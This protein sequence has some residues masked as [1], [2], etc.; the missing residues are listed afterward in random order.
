MSF[1][2]KI[3][4]YFRNGAGLIKKAARNGAVE[5][6]I[7][8]LINKAIMFISNIL[9]IRMLDTS[10]YGVFSYIYNIISI[11][12]IF[13]SLG[14]DVTMLQFCCENRPLEE[15]RGIANF[16][17]PVGIAIN[18]TFS[19]ATFFIA[20]FAP[21]KFPEGRMI[22]M[23]FSF[24][25]PF[26]FILNYQKNILRVQK[27]NRIFSLLTN[28]ASISYLI[29]S[30]IFIKFYGMLGATVGRF[31]AYVIPIVFG[32]LFTMHV[33]NDIRKSSFPVKS[34][35]ISIF[36]YGLT[37]ALTNGVSEL[38]YYLDVY[39]IGQVTTDAIAI[40]NYKSATLIPRAMVSLPTIIVTFIYPY[41]A[42]N[43]DKHDWVLR[44][45][46]KLELI[47]FPLC[48][49]AAAVLFIIAPW[50][51][52]F[53]YG[54]EY[55]DSLIPFR[56]LLV[57][58]VF[59]GSFRVLSGNILLMIGKVKANFVV[60]CIECVINVI[61]DY[62]LIK[63]FNTVGAAVATLSVT[64]ISSILT[65]GFLFIYLKKKINATRLVESDTT[66][67]EDTVH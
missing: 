22:F 33:F 67:E 38:L 52:E 2:S 8:S 21:I 54:S 32:F 63:H 26:P 1:I 56:I 51:I 37:I 60:G 48:V 29:C 11:V 9:I 64:V 35:I 39:V 20:F 65:N 66:N 50:L 4:G 58:F 45:T 24:I 31:L 59:S 49:I 61:L 15:R 6:V 34:I 17:L 40:A 27:K 13:S 18:L 62:I 30:V 14:L 57:S 43:K 46:I 41:F 7:S 36:K 16:I 47:V 23:V 42:F 44:N 55:I 5:I 53:L 28:I 25:F 12:L 19:I 3:G 10:E